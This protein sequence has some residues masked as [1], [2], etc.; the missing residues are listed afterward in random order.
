M[1]FESCRIG[2]MDKINEEV[3]PQKQAWIDS[4]LVNEPKD[5][6]QSIEKKLTLRKINGV[7]VAFIADDHSD[8]DR[9]N[10]A[11]Q[12]IIQSDQVGGVVI[13][14]FAPELKAVARD[15]GPLTKLFISAQLN[16]EKYRTRLFSFDYLARLVKRADKA[17]YVADIA[18]KPD[19]MLLRTFYDYAP[20]IVLGATQGGVVAPLAY[21][22]GSTLVQEGVMTTNKRNA[23]EKLMLGG[24]DARR[25]FLARG[26]DTI[27]KFL[28]PEDKE[29]TL[30]VVY[31]QAHI[32]RV[33]HYLDQSN[34]IKEKV[35]KVL[36]PT[37]DFKVRKYMPY[38]GPQTEE[39]RKFSG[40]LPA[41]V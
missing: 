34:S 5:I 17:V 15:S 26:I 24:E 3:L 2:K 23:F 4:I 18:N 39:S 35:Y 31:P 27:T 14:Y 20:G 21:G 33:C 11:L 41:K 29:K 10:P 22:F 19:Y 8:K 6:R 9:N 40:W 32:D 28:G 30:V 37:M 13:E 1:I 7:N 12:K 25:V 16:S 38:S 36:F